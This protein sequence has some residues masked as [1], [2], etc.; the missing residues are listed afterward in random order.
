MELK[1]YALRN[2]HGMTTLL[3]RKLETAKEVRDVLISELRYRYERIPKTDRFA[4][5]SKV[6]DF[7]KFCECFEIHLSV[8]RIKSQP[9][10]G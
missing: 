7:K 9:E 5:P 4:V 2:Y 3:L 6:D 1:A 10:S 8:L